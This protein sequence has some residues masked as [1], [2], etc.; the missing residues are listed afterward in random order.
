[1]EILELKPDEVLH[2]GDSFNNDILGART[3]G[4]PGFWINRKEKLVPAGEAAP[5]YMGAT[6]MELL[7]IIK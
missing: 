1:L 2:V 5:D 6:L 7:K 4:I 3:L